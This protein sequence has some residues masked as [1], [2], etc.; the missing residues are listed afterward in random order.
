VAALGDDPDA[1]ERLARREDLADLARRHRLIG[2]LG[3]RLGPYLGVTD[4][5]PWVQT[6]RSET[7]RSL[8]LDAHLQQL[9]RLLGEAAIPWMVFK[10]MDLRSRAYQHPI[11]RPVADIDILLDHQQYSAAQSLLRKA[12]WAD[13]FTR[14][15]NERFLQEEG[16]CWNGRR[17]DGTCLE[18]HFRLWGLVPEDWSGALLERGLPAPELGPTARRPRWADAYLLAAVHLWMNPAPDTLLSFWDLEK[19]THAA[20]SGWAQEVAEQV[21][22]WDLQLPVALAAAAAHSWWPAS[23]H[24]ECSRE[25]L[26]SFSFWERRLFAAAERRQ[27]WHRVSLKQIVLSRLLSK[28]RSRM[29]WKTLLRALWAHAGIVERETDPGK[30]WALRRWNHVTSR[31][32]RI[33]G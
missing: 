24:G 31:L 3:L 30:P 28:R 32:R 17:P 2:A 11:E 14:P 5:E 21:R 9:G 10:G 7:A 13:V 26:P 33:G 19:I 1:L 15:D 12:G 20:P 25:L 22:L 4:L 29:G 18:V 6:L 8:L 27:S 16:Y 23:G